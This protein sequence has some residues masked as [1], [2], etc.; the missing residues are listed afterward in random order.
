MRWGLGCCNVRGLAM[1]LCGSVCVCLYLGGSGY[2][3]SSVRRRCSRKEVEP[4]CPEAACRKSMVRSS[5]TSYTCRSSCSSADSPDTSTGSS[6]GV[7]GSTCL[8][9]LPCCCSLMR[10]EGQVKAWAVTREG[11]LGV[12]VGGCGRSRVKRVTVMEK[13]SR[14]GA[15]GQCASECRR[16][17]RTSSTSIESAP[18]TGRVR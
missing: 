1:W 14:L 10:E 2:L 17:H 6:T 9:L 18:G 11:P 15:L 13:V 4:G 7:L 3:L 16:E 12:V 5:V 8:L